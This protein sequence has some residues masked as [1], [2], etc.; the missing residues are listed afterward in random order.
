MKLLL[1]THILLWWLG[2]SP[3]LSKRSREQIANPEHLI[4]VSVATAW[5]ISIKRALGKL[6]APNDLEDALQSNGFET[7]PIKLDHALLAGALPRHHDDPFDRL[8]IAQSK[9]EHFTLLTQDKHFTLY[10]I[11][12]I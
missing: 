3:K 5:E 6:S 9:L 7:L 10:D 8:I 11:R 2:D 12:T 1:D 4:Y